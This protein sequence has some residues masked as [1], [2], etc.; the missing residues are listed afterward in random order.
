MLEECWK[1]YDFLERE[2][3]TL[4]SALKQAEAQQ[5]KESCM[6]YKRQAL[7][8][9]RTMQAALEYF[10]ADFAAELEEKSL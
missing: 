6:R 5:D 9:L 7:M 2:L 4:A 8:H 1:K 3:N 10:V